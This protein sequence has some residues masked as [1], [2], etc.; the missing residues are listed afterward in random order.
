MFRAG[1]CATLPTQPPSH[2]RCAA[3]SGNIGGGSDTGML[4]AKGVMGWI[5]HACLQ[6]QSPRRLPRLRSWALFILPLPV[7]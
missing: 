5:A 4:H 6:L 3:G 7:S 2:P 1:P